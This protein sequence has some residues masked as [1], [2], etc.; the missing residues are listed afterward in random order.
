VREPD[1]RFSTTIHPP[2][3]WSASGN[4]ERDAQTIMQRLMDT[5]Q[6]AVRARPDQWYMFRPMWPEQ[7]PA[8]PAGRAEPAAGGPAS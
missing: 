3:A 1:L 6:S 7:A 4:R 8:V 5:L 2:I